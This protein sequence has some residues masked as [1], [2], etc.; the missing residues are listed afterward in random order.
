MVVSQV[1]F[2]T[3]IA[4]EVNVA[5]LAVM[6]QIRTATYVL[7]LLLL[8]FDTRRFTH[9]PSFSICVVLFPDE[10]SLFLSLREKCR[11]LVSLV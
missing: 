2:K 10:P 6:L 8:L 5:I 4:F 9:C 7:L 11:L 3:L 1:H